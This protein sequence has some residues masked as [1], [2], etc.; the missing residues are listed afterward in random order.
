MAM[1]N[2]ISQSF[3]SAV[4]SQAEGW[5]VREGAVYLSTEASG[6]EDR[7]VRLEVGQAWPFPNGSTVY[8]RAASGSARISREPIA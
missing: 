3:T 5:Q 4:L 2:N 1:I 8:Y 6:D 7:G